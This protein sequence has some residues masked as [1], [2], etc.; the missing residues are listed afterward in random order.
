MACATC[1]VAHHVIGRQAVGRICRKDAP[2]RQAKATRGIHVLLAF[3]T[4]AV[5][6]TVRAYTPTARYEGDHDLVDALTEN[7][8]QHKCY[9][10][11]RN[12]L[13]STMRM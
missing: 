4:S 6:R 3:S 1:T 2:W 7:G 8:E 10:Y 9:E 13:Q 5:P 12:M 11:R